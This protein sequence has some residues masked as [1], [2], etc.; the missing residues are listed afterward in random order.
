MLPGSGTQCCDEFGGVACSA[1]G[2]GPP[3]GA[4]GDIEVDGGQAEP[5]L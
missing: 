3:L 4:L 2:R 5:A 1:M